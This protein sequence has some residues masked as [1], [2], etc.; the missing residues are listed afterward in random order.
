MVLSREGGPTS[1][2]PG[3]LLRETVT[4]VPKEPR[5]RLGLPIHGVIRFL[6]LLRVWI[7]PEEI[8]NFLSKVS[9]GPFPTLTI[10]L[11]I[12]APGFDDGSARTHGVSIDG[13]FPVKVEGSRAPTPVCVC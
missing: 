7:A 2:G 8:S 6:I 12:S 9:C 4:R 5:C 13:W 1:L 10:A 3:V 11:L